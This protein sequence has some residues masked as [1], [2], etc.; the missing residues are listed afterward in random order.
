MPISGLVLTLS[1]DPTLRASAL[2]AVSGNVKIE[3]GRLARQRLPSVVD[4]ASSCEDKA[5]W[6]WLHELPG[7]LFVDLVSADY[8]ED[9]PEPPMRD[10]E[11]VSHTPGCGSERSGARSPC[12]RPVREGE[13][14]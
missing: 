1:D 8:S 4:T 2:E 12:I 11:A 5:V 13:R 10:Q 9:E 6:E 14:S 3:P 7:V